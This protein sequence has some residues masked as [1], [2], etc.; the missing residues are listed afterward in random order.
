MH[1]LPFRR[2]Q[3]SSTPVILRHPTGSERLPVTQ[4]VAGSSPVVPA[5]AGG[6]RNFTETNESLCEGV[7]LTF[8]SGDQLAQIAADERA[9]SV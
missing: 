9:P 2:A 8:A 7:W 5:Q 6:G 4:E 3:A 1:V